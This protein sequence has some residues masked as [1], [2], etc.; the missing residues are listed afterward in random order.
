MTRQLT[1]SLLE[2]LEVFP[3]CVSLFTRI[4]DSIIGRDN[5]TTVPNKTSEFATY[6]PT[7]TPAKAIDPRISIR[8]EV[9][10]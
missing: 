4:T 5:T 1:A 10:R 8:V 6:D 2:F 7:M 3:C 9:F